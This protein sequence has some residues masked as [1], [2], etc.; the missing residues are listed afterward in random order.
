MTIIAIAI[1]IALSLSFTT[2]FY[3]HKQD[4]CYWCKKDV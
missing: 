4:F 2:L 1:V 3:G